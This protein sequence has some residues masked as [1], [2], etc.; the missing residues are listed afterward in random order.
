MDSHGVTQG[1]EASGIG[2]MHGASGGQRC[3]E[4]FPLPT[5]LG[6]E[7]GRL[8]FDSDVKCRRH[9]NR[10]RKGEQRSI[11][12]LEALNS[13]VT[14]TV[15][16]GFFDSHADVGHRGPPASARMLPFVNMAELLSTP[17]WNSS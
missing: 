10:V 1:T 17:P 11:D 16:S 4:L 15:L 2:C 3:R 13:L 7:P 5:V 14:D 6:L 8:V 9:Y 12:A